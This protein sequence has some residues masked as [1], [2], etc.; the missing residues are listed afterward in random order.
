MTELSNS[1][2]AAR[3][4]E[5][6]ELAGLSQAQ[7]A[8]RLNLHRPAISEIEAGRRRVSAPEVAVL[9]ELSGVSVEWITT[10]ESVV[11]DRRVRLVARELEKLK[12][13]DLDK[14]MSVLRTLK[15]RS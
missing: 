13:A 6:R 7:A 12:P 10:G 8:K 11:D 5:A 14:L 3:L 15:K 4:R 2:V 1:P 9:A